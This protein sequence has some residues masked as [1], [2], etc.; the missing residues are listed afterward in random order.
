MNKL[1]SAMEDFM[2]VKF[3]KQATHSQ[4]LFTYVKKRTW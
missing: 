1:L 4:T 2:I 3:K